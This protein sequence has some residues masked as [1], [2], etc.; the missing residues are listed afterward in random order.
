MIVFNHYANELLSED[1]IH[2]I[3]VSEK[4]PK[5]HVE[6]VMWSCLHADFE[7]DLPDRNIALPPYLLAIPCALCNCSPRMPTNVEGQ[8]AWATPD[9][10]VP[11]N[12]LRKHVIEV[13]GLGVLSR[14]GWREYRAWMVI[15]WQVTAICLLYVLVP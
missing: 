14:D 8:G 7:I 13:S 2:I 12:G 1:F 5:L 4:I 11:T 10:E 6:N 9:I 15:M 3:A